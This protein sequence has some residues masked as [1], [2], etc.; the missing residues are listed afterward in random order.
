MRHLPVEHSVGRNLTLIVESSPKESSETESLLQTA[1]VRF[2]R[3]VELEKPMD[4]IS[5]VF[6][7]SGAERWLLPK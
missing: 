7:V 1:W 4:I 5:R 3:V 6:V 2:R